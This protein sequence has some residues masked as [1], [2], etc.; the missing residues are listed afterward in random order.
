VYEDNEDVLVPE[1]PAV[2]EVDE[3]ADVEDEETGG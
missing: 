2:E 1:E 3:E